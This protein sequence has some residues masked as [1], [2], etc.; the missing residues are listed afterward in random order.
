MKMLC[1]LNKGVFPNDTA[2]TK[3]VYLAYCNARKKWTMPI[4]NWGMISQ[5]LAI[6]FGDRYSL[7]QICYICHG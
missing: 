2:L 5:Q 6:K 4:P 1:G 7:L 3:L